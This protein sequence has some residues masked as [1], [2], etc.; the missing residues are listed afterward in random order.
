MI[1]VQISVLNIK[2]LR[3]GAHLV[4]SREHP[5]AHD[6]TIAIRR[7]AVRETSVSRHHGGPIDGPPE[8]PRASQHYRIEGI[9]GVPDLG[10]L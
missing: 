7:E 5:G 8:T 6:Q 4:A 1:L 3:C 9:K 10:T 2:P